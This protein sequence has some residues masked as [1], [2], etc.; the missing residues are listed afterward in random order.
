[1][2]FVPHLSPRMIATRKTKLMI[3]KCQMKHK[4]V[5]ETTTTLRSHSILGLDYH[6]PELG[7][8]LRQ[9]IMGIRLS[10]HPDRLLFVAVTAVVV[11]RS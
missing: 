1:M 5:V 10:Q 6:I 3:K 8:T 9:A 11:D 4:T 7:I 2:K